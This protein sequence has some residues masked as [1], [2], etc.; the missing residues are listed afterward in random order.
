MHQGSGKVWVAPLAPW[1]VSALGIRS[2][3]MKQ[4]QH[5]EH[6]PIKLVERYTG[7]KTRQGGSS[8]LGTNKNKGLKV[9]KIR[10][11]S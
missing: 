10:N 8:E 11:Y 9:T 7:A 3:R 1:S 6:E 5:V 4:P 2:L